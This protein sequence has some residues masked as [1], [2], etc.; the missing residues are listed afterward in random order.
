MRVAAPLALRPGDEE[1]LRKMASA[2]S[3]PAA[4]ARRARVVLLAAGGLPNTVIVERAGL[5][6]PSVRH[7][8]ARYASGGI[9]ALGDAPRSGRPRTVDEIEIVVRTLEP[10]PGRL[11]V[12]HWSSRLLARELGISTASIIEVWR[13]YGLQP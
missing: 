2:R 13:S 3:G 9:G 12:T 4:L 1:E 7:W 10:P 11:G 6:L 5:S 8:R